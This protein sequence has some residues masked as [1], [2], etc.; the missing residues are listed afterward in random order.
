V[1][2]SPTG[3]GIRRAVEALIKE[4][5]PS[6]RV[7]VLTP[8]AVL[9]EQWRDRLIEGPDE[10]SVTLL[11]TSEAALAL[12]DNPD[13]DQGLGRVVVSTTGKAIRGLSGRALAEFDY[14]LVVLDD[15]RPL[16]VARLERLL[17]R[18]GRVVALTSVDASPIPDWPV[19][20]DFSL[21]DIEAVTGRPLYSV[22]RYESNDAE[23]RL[24]READQLLLE[25]AEFAARPDE[26]NDGG[27]L[28]ALHST[29]LGLA[30]NV[31]HAP[32]PRDLQLRPLRDR[33][34]KQ[35][36][37]LIDRVESASD[38]DS[39]LQTLERLVMTEVEAGSRCV[40]V[41]LK[42][43]DVSYI[44][45]H[46]ADV[47]HRPVGMVSSLTELT[48]RRAV[49]SSLK[50]GHVAVSS[51]GLATELANV[52]TP[53]TVVLWSPAALSQVMDRVGGAEGVRIVVLVGERTSQA[54]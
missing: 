28:A 3:I 46:L 10:L 16:I 8:Y 17:G 19:V 34:L 22:L 49:L 44:A 29:L 14:G 42:L 41:A 18:A 45:S 39:R 26:R 27:G 33:I 40:V 35:V 1:V 2:R 52:P 54:V 11:E 23:S 47:G 21:S 9:A 51:A 37:G 31:E 25:Y 30:A 50:P 43:S 38:G 32:E 5:A 36:W 20:V 53:C 6:S 24:Q 4:V 13:D 7:L 12:L 15:A 48:A